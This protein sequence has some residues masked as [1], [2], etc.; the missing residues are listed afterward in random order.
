MGSRLWNARG[1]KATEGWN[2]QNFFSRGASIMKV[3]ITGGAGFIGHNTAIFLKHRGYDV[4]AFDNLKRSASLAQERLRSEGIPLLKGDILREG[5]LKRALEGTDVVVHAAAYIC[6]EES[7][8]KPAL[9]FKNNVGGT[10][11]LARACLLKDVQRIIYLSSAAVYGDP[12]ALPIDEDHPTVPISPYG[13]SKLMG[14][15]VVRFYARHGLKYAILRLFN[16]YGVGQSLAYAGVIARF[17]EKASKGKPPVIYGD[18]KQTR[19]F[20]NVNDVA[21]AI[22][23][24]IEARTV[25]ET[26]NIATGR[27]TEIEELAHIIIGL[28]RLAIKPKY[29]KP[30]TGDIRQSYAD[31]SKARRVLGFTPKVGL[32]EGLRELMNL[33]PRRSVGP[34]WQI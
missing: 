7:M 4:I 5:D 14:E 19:D 3:V 22:M 26:F 12:K 8:K 9:Y 23:L 32:E 15:E 25:N 31:V 10:A 28:A 16:V 21:E 18:G 34:I 2:H 33:S 1:G 30:K 29:K 13:L 24:S 6:V 11:N 20:I 27:P 17:I